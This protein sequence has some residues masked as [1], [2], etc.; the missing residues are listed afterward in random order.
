MTEGLR[1]PRPEDASAVAELMSRD[2]PEPV[3]PERVLGEWTFP[4]V[5]L[6]KDARLDRGAYVLVD[7]FGDERVWIDVAG[8]PT[9]ELLD[10]A[11]SRARELGSRLLAG[12][13]TTQEPLLAELERRK[14]RQVRTSFRMA[15]DL[16]ASTPDPLW[17]AGVEPRA[18]R[19]GDER[20]FYELHQE[21]FADAWEPI[22]ETYEEW[23]HQFLG[24]DT[25]APG[26]WTLAVANG[27]PVGL[28]ICHPHAVDE[29]LGWV[30]ILGVR[31]PHRGRGLGRALL[32]RAFAQFRLQGMRRVGLGVD[33]N[34]PTRA[35]A[36]YESVGMRVVARFAIYEK[37]VA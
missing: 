11:E 36:L 8:R 30:R 16:D 9:P 24:A 17:P 18:F 23:A 14:F 2:A 3:G 15:I 21:T 1:I 37:A 5:Q 32:L 7:G 4:G 6:E 26:L 33:G 28:A 25:F 34:S 19:P 27:D 29:E 12:G 22:D 35:N 13:W 20:I 10:W 31:R